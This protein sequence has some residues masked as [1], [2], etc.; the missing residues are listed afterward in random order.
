MNNE[1][2]DHLVQILLIGNS[3]V[4][5]TSLVQRFTSNNYTDNY[6]ATIGIDF[7]LKIFEINN[8]KLKLQIWDTAGQERFSNLTANFYKSAQ[9]IIVVY[10]ISDEAS[11]EAINRWI[12]QIQTNAPKNVQILLVGSKSDLEEYRVIS[13][14]R[15]A[16]IR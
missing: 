8:V 12:L 2:Y 1:T 5:K 16:L 13:T 6:L 9:G 7:K 14:E 10:S 11:F 4:G 3:S 15:G